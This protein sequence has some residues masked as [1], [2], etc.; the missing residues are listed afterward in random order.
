MRIR[1][2]GSSSSARASSASVSRRSGEFASSEIVNATAHEPSRPASETACRAS[3]TPRRAMSIQCCASICD[4]A[5]RATSGAERI[6][7][8]SVEITSHPVSA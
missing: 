6:D 5:W 1:S 2:G 8:V 3:R 4:P 7:H